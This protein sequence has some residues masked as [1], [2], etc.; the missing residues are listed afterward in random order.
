[1]PSRAMRSSGA[2]T[3]RVSPDSATALP[4]ASPNT[5]S[6]SGPTGRASR[7]SGATS[8]SRASTEFQRRGSGAA[9]AERGA[10]K[11]TTSNPN[12]MATHARIV[13]PP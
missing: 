8:A 3:S 6:L 10:S 5:P 2:P 9:S 4:S 13:T 11:H 1:M 7:A 12:A